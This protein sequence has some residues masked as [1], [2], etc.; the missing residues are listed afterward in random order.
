MKSTSKSY[1]D[2]NHRATALNNINTN[3]IGYTYSIETSYSDPL[4]SLLHQAV[5]E[6]ITFSN[7]FPVLKSSSEEVWSKTHPRVN[8][9]RDKVENQLVVDFVV[10]YYKK[11]DLTLEIDDSKR[12]IQLTGKNASENIPESDHVVRSVSRGSFKKSL[13][14]EPSEAYDLNSIQAIHQD[15]VLRLK[16]DSLKEK[17]T[18][19][20]VDIK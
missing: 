4:N 17:V 12:L 7:K 6:F 2:N 5:D 14:L 19:R 8:V 20:K 13:F 1:L 10:P 9:F 15:G 16:F 3:P 11:D 18:N